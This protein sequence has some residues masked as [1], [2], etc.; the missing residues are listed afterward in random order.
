MLNK[1]IFLLAF[2]LITAGCTSE[3]IQGTEE[4][5]LVG[6]TMDDEAF[7]GDGEDTLD[8][9]KPMTIAEFIAYINLLDEAVKAQDGGELVLTEVDGDTLEKVNEVMKATEF[10]DA[11]LEQAK[12]DLDQ[13]FTP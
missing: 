6:G 8:Q 3:V 4:E 13:I 2:I 10:A 9:L 5:A 7:A 1:L 11:D 12:T